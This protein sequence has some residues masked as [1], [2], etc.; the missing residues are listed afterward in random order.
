MAED[1]G[2]PYRQ[3]RFRVEIHGI[4]QAGFAEVLMPKSSLELIEYWEGE[5]PMP[6]TVLSGRADHENLILRWGITDNLELFNW[7]NIVQRQGCAEHKKN[8]SIILM[9][10]AGNDK[11]KWSLT[12]AWPVTYEVSDLN[13]LENGVCLEMIE[14]AF[15]RLLRSQIKASRK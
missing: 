9:D 10:D 15:D 2:E 1:F 12:N 3:H 6:V 11:I 7:W 4:A 5:K 8:L 13:A 14:I